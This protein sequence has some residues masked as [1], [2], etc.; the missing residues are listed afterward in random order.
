MSLPNSTAA[1]S[2][3]GSLNCDAPQNCST[4]ANDT[5]ARSRP[6]KML[7]CWSGQL[8]QDQAAMKKIYEISEADEI[9]RE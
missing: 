1:E 9:V 2:A 5:M 7:V 3:P 4:T 8:S 6:K